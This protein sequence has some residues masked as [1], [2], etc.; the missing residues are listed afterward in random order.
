D[1]DMTSTV[2]GVALEW[3]P[4][5]PGQALAAPTGAMAV[6]L[7]VI[8]FLVRLLLGVADAPG[9]RDTIRTLDVVVVPLFIALAFIL[10]TRVLEILPLGGAATG[11]SASLAPGPGA[12]ALRP[13]PCVEPADGPATSRQRRATRPP[14]RRGARLRA[15]R[16]A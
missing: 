3:L 1:R 6:S 14:A 5:T 8:A 10:S 4:Q 15:R 12:R 13:G 2:T 11:A 16:R 9:S 7:L